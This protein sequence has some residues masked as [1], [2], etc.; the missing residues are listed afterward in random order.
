MNE[1]ETMEARPGGPPT[2]H[3]RHAFWKYPVI[4]VAVLGAIV[5]LAALLGSPNWPRDQ[6]AGR[7]DP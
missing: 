6:I 3:V 1:E 5:T 2:H 4:A 7:R